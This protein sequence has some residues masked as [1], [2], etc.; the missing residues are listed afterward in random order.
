MLDVGALIDTLIAEVEGLARV[1]RAPAALP[2]RKVL[3]E[4]VTELLWATTLTEEGRACR[5][6]LLFGEPSAGACHRFQEPLPLTRECLRKVGSS[7]GARG[8][9]MWSVSNGAALLTGIAPRFG[10]HPTNLILLAPAV[11]AL[12]AIWFGERFVSLREGETRTF[13][14]CGLPNLVSATER[15][16]EH[17]GAPLGPDFLG[18]IVRVIMD[19]GHGGAVWM[20]EP[21]VPLRVTKIHAIQPDAVFSE[22]RPTTLPEATDY[23]LWQESI[24]ELASI[25]GALVLDSAMGVGGFGAY[26]EIPRELPDIRWHSANGETRPIPAKRLGGGRHLSAVAFCAEHAPAAALVISSD[27]RITLLTCARGDGPDA[28]E[29]VSLGRP[30]SYGR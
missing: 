17:F 23:D 1:Y 25:D 6:R 8:Y 10:S 4:V 5:P 15:M 30:A 29:V 27:G 24:G 11:L 20:T 21:G 7:H 19:S 9:L 3:V 26:V 13:S 12:D 22:T 2:P 28:W 16:G 18:P 14:E